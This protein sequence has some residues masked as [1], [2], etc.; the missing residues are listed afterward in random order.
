MA[1][2]PA[3]SARPLPRVMVI[4]KRLPDYFADNLLTTLEDR[5]HETRSVESFTGR[6]ARSGRLG[7]RLREEAH[8][9]PKL[10]HRLHRHVREAA[11]DFR[12][13][14]IVN[15][16]SRLGYPMVSE[17][18][19]V[20]GAP[21]V[22][23]F[24]DSPGNLRRET[25]VLAGYDALFL[26]DSIIVDRYRQ[27]FG[28]NAF[29][30]AQGCNPRWHRPVGP[31]AGASDSPSVVLAGNMYATRFVLAREL[32][33]LGIGVEIYGSPWPKWLPTDSRLLQGY[34][35]RPVFREE[36]ARVFRSASVVLNS[37]AS[38]EADG[39]NVRLFEAAACGAVVLTEWRAR[40]AEMF[41]VPAEVRSYRSLA[42][43]AEQVRE[44]SA[45][46]MPD[47]ETLATAASERAHAE[48]SY[49]HRFDQMLHAIGRG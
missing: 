1:P 49:E 23:W 24:P 30:L 35:G 12:P 8:G 10:A 31:L 9:Y 28:L 39:L 40:L 5:G 47:R 3:P 17:L 44:L 21:I 33:R 20:S 32:L 26:K 2:V 25:H 46:P 43:L 7:A 11:E 16:D 41:E 19:D 14:V 27:V 13:D 29:Y 48:H 15:L 34:H 38:H 36:K 6:A 37:M 18:R 42:E 45:L 4:G 22:F